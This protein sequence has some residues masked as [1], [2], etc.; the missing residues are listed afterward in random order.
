MDQYAPIPYRRRSRAALRSGWDKQT[1]ASNPDCDDGRGIRS[2][3]GLVLTKPNICTTFPD[4]YAAHRFFGDLRIRYR[5]RRGG[6]YRIRYFAHHCLWRTGVCSVR[7]G[8]DGA[9][10]RS[11]TPYQRMALRNSAVRVRMPQT[12]DIS[13]ESGAETGTATDAF[14]LQSRFWHCP[15]LLCAGQ[16]EVKGPV[17]NADNITIVVG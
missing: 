15:R 3:C 12:G 7:V 4:Y 10:S 6:P 9:Y 17:S 2:S 14:G 5:R 11:S 13:E 16:Y 1:L 8:V